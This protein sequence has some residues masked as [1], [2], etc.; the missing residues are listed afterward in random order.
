MRP[1]LFEQGMVLACREDG[2]SAAGNDTPYYEEIE[3][4]TNTL[5]DEYRECMK[6]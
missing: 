2:S 1:Q 3:K 5:K 6:A 4:L